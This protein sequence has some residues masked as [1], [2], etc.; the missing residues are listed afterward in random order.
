MSTANDTQV[1]TFVNGRVRPRCEQA[2]DLAVLMLEDIAGIDDIYN[3]LNVQ[4][5]TWSD[6][7]TDGPPHLATPSDVLAFNAFM[8]DVS[9][10]I[11]GHGQYAIV[12]KLCVRNISG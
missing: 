6:S 2:R 11:T 12:R 4:S 3:A 7:R 9:A 10:Y 1:Q 8:H 5:P